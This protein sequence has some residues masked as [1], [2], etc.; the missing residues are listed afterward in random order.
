M[1]TA[2]ARGHKNV[3]VFTGDISTFDLP[4]EYYGIAD[5]IISIEM[6]EHMKNYELLLK[7]VSNWMKSGGYLFIHIFTA[8]ECPGHFQKGWMTEG[9]FAAVSDRWPDRAHR[10]PGQR[11]PR[12]AVVAVRHERLTRI[13]GSG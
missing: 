1:S 7:K 3:N 9:W 4:K 12:R 2:T 5:R 10:I 11:G 6:F 8:R 13:H